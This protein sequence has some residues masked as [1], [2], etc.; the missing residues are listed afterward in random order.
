MTMSLDKQRKVLEE[1]LR[2]G[3]LTRERFDAIMMAADS[4]PRNP[5]KLLEF[6]GMLGHLERCGEHVIDTIRMAKLANRRLN[7]GWSR[8]RWREEHEA[9][10]RQLTAKRRREQDDLAFDTGWLEDILGP[11]R[12]NV[13]ISIFASSMDLVR[14]GEV[15]GHCI[16]TYVDQFRMGRIGGLS[17]VL[18]GTRW[19]VTIKPPIA[20]GKATVYKLNGRRNSTP[21]VATRRRILRALGPRVV[22]TR[23]AVPATRHAPR[24]ETYVWEYCLP[25]HLL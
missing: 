25:K 12:K 6:G 13:N 21:S 17:L 9:L 11:A 14:E 20:G 2:A 4:S 23:E 7:L 10:T 8:R 3:W 15:Q 24:T 19:T 18:D 5:E 1:L 22:D 16:P